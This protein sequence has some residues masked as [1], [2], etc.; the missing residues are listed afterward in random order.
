MADDNV[1]GGGRGGGSP[2]R[3][4]KHDCGRCAA[5]LRYMDPHSQCV[6][7]R[8]HFNCV[9]P[10]DD[11]QL[12]GDEQEADFLVVLRRCLTSP[13][14]ASNSDPAQVMAE[15][16]RLQA[17]LPKGG[18]T[19]EAGR[20]LSSVVNPP[21]M[22]FSGADNPKIPGF[23]SVVVIDEDEAWLADCLPAGHS[24]VPESDM[25]GG[26]T[27]THS[28][29]LVSDVV[30]PSYAKTHEESSTRV[31][32]RTPAKKR[33][34]RSHKHS[35]SRIT[36]L[37]EGGET[38]YRSPPRLERATSAPPTTSGPCS[39]AASFPSAS[40]TSISGV[41]THPEKLRGYPG[42][43]TAVGKGM[44]GGGGVLTGPQ[45]QRQKG[46]VLL[47]IPQSYPP[48]CW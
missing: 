20:V 6:S 22:E 11:R 44:T 4:L 24:G 14:V 26:N 8:G 42:G 9:P 3:P 10:C 36:G 13:S 43:S 32:G 39:S 21:P 12:F 7:C 1:A 25:G 34:S 29:P 19:S 28:Q 31:R 16:T 23:N 30:P 18:G 38:S 27:L 46:N 17:L 37:G 41:T 40:H 35:T 33:K 5:P 15:I 45:N 47:N 48:E 2:S